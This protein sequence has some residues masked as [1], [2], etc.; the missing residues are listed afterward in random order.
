MK[1][2]TTLLILFFLVSASQLFSQENLAIAGKVLDD[3]NQ[4]PVAYAN[5]SLYSLSDS[6]L[7]KGAITNENG[8]FGINDLRPNDYYVKV[9]YI[10]YQNKV[11]DKVSLSKEKPNVSLGTIAMAPE[12][13]ELGEVTVKEDKLKGQEKVDRTVY[14]V[15]AK[16]Q[17]VS[18]NGLDVLKHIPSVSVDFQENVTLA[19]RSDIL[20]FVDDI[21]R[22]KDFVAQLD[23]SSIDRVEIMTNPSSK[24]D[25]D[26][27]G[28]IHIYLKKKTFWLK[29]QSICWYPFPT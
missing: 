28:I 5:V 4:Q 8:E 20:F 16:V 22:D 29:R 24:Y 7:V 21:Q 23:P 26:I 12:D 11:V 25:A 17:E 6:S 18:T 14:N 19:G 3:K 2:L 10:G 9:S 27:S 1:K 13:T 15:T